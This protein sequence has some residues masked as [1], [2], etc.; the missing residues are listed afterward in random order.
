MRIPRSAEV[1][2][3]W[4]RSWRPRRWKLCKV[5]THWTIYCAKSQEDT[6]RLLVLLVFCHAEELGPSQRLR[7]TESCLQFIYQHEERSV[8]PT[9][10]L[11]GAQSL[12][13]EQPLPKLANHSRRSLCW[14]PQV[15]EIPVVRNF[16]KSTNH[17]ESLLGARS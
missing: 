1:L 12:E 13:H 10:L 4:L 11:E 6:H 16:R 7:F 3:C 14:E 17:K 8:S 2:E 5:S 15:G 9:N